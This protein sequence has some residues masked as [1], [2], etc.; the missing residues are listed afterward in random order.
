[1]TSYAGITKKSISKFDNPIE[2]YVKKEEK[3]ID[4]VKY[5]KYLKNTKDAIIGLMN[6]NNYHSN[7]AIAMGSM[8]LWILCNYLKNKGDIKDIG[9]EPND[10]DIFMTCSISSSYYIP[11]MLETIKKDCDIDFEINTTLT[12]GLKCDDIDDYIEKLSELCDINIT[13]VMMVA[14]TKPPDNTVFQCGSTVVNVRNV[15]SKKLNFYIVCSQCVINCIIGKKAFYYSYIDD[16]NYVSIYDDKL[17]QRRKKY[18]K[19]GFKLIL[20]STRFINFDITK[21]YYST[22]N[23]MFE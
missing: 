6:H 19:R 3:N 15:T 1:M 22:Y 5:E 23:E 11:E 7:T 17:K 8:P 13:S 14:S 16:N 21:Y 10:I 12:S 20:D 4:N 2:F 18:I 9:F